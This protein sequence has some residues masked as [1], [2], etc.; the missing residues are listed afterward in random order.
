MGL[1]RYL[2][3]RLTGLGIYGL[4]SL[5]DSPRRSLL[6]RV[7]DKKSLLELR[8]ALATHHGLEL[9]DHGQLAPLVREEA[10]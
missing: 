7:L 6:P 8:T 2:F 10:A 1:S 9:D 3:R 5:R 4:R